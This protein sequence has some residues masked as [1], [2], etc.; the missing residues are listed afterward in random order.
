MTVYQLSHGSGPQECL[1]AQSRTLLTLLSNL[2]VF[3]CIV[4]TDH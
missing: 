2:A 1:L 4:F 3:N